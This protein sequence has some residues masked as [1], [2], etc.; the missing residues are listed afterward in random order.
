MDPDIRHVQQLPR[1]IP[2]PL[3]SKVTEAIQSGKNG[4][5]K[6]VT[7]T[8][9][10][11]SN[12]VVIKK[13]GKVRTCLDP[14]TPN[15]ALKQS[16]SQMPT[17]EEILPDIAEAKVFSVLDTKDGYWQ[18]KLATESNYLTILW[19]PLGRFSWLRIPFGIKPAA[20]EDQRRQHKAL[21]DRNF[22]FRHAT[23]QRG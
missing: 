5:I 20:E 16:H 10:W 19:S 8:T 18:V 11:I 12:M 3:I 22:T 14:S 6:R 2:I 17:I 15:K 7:Q 4:I 1:Q 21:H 13:P 23:G 9:Q